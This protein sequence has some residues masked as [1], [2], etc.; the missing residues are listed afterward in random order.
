[1]NKFLYI[2]FIFILSC[3]L[4]SNSAFWSKSE[5]LKTDKK[6][7]RV[8]FEDLKPNENEFNPKLKVNLP[9]K[10]LSINYNFNNNGFTTEQI[11]GEN[12]SRYKF[13]KIEN[14]S[15][16]EPEILVEGGGAPGA[17]RVGEG[18][19]VGAQDGAQH[20][21]ADGDGGATKGGG[22]AK[23]G[24]ACDLPEQGHGA[25]RAGDDEPRIMR[26]ARITV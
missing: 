25:H 3:S 18:R 13:A 10:K 14:F 26:V 4:N 12:Y 7:S 16:F 17:V 24:G 8:L 21:E 6:I 19:Q 20:A 15:G 9:I 22:E 5:K 2:I 11:S 1:M 23:G